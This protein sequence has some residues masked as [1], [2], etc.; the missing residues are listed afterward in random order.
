MQKDAFPLYSLRLGHAQNLLV[1]VKDGNMDD[2]YAR[3][4]QKL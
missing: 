4:R 2:K 3:V 1:N